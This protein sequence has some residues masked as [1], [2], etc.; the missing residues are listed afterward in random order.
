MSSRAGIFTTTTLFFTDGKT[1]EYFCVHR[2]SLT[3]SLCMKHG[4]LFQL[5]L[6]VCIV[7]CTIGNIALGAF[8]AV[9]YAALLAFDYACDKAP[10]QSQGVCLS[11]QDFGWN[12][13]YCGGWISDQ[14]GSC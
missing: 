13:V 11:L 6:L 5:I 8:G 2:A 1:F 10:Q 14:Y 12:A 4:W 9:S 3:H 7:C